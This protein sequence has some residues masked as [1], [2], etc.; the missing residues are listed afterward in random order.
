M[1]NVLNFE[2]KSKILKLKRENEVL[3]R[4]ISTYDHDKD[5][6]LQMMRRYDNKN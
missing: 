4:I 3:K 6:A 2:V 5:E 1:S